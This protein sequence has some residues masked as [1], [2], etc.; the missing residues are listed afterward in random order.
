MLCLKTNANVD[1]N[2]MGGHPFWLPLRKCRGGAL[3]E[4]ERHNVDFNEVGGHPLVAPLVRKSTP[5]NRVPQSVSV[6]IETYHA[7]IPWYF[8]LFY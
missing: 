4:N 1:L 7:S 6:K 3:F 5:G 8:I 2:V